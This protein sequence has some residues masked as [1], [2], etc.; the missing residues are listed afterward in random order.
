MVTYFACH[1]FNKEWL[2]IEMAFNL[3]S[4]EIDWDSMIVPNEDL[5]KSNWQ[6][7]YMEQYLNADGTEK[8]CEAYD[9]PEINP[10]RVAFFIYKED[11]RT[12]RTSYGDFD[13]TN[14]QTL[15]ER[16]KNIIEFEED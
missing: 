5:D 8:I 10:C 2:L 16:L 11:S 12:L 13:L 3:S 7:P 9:R 6:C 1:E 4:S 15:P 14:T